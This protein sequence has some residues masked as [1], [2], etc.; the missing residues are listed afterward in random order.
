MINFDDM[1]KLMGYRR[2]DIHSIYGMDTLIGTR[3]MFINRVSGRY[4]P[5]EVE[6]S[7]RISQRV[8]SIMVDNNS[9]IDS[10]GCDL[11]VSH[12]LL[13]AC[14]LFYWS[15]V[16]LDESFVEFLD[17]FLLQLYDDKM[18]VITKNQK[19]EVYYPHW[20]NILNT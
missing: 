20:W 17:G 12:D 4:P 10:D 18:V 7:I 9:S 1:E 15:G 5:W 3:Q 8:A 2:R 14:L 6:E 13:I 11:Y 19:R 16:T